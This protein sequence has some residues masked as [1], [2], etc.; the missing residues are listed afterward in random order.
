MTQPKPY[1]AI[2][3]TLTLDGL[4]QEQLEQHYKLYQGYVANTNTLNERIAELIQQGKTG[5]PEYNEMKRRFGFEYSGMRLHEFY[6][7]NL[8]QN[9]GELAR[10]SKLGRKIAEDF[11]SVEN[12]MA[13]F[14]AT[15]LM[16]GIGWVIL[17]QDPHTGRLQT[18]W[19]GDHENG[20]PAGFQPILVM[21]V[22][23]HA[24]T[25]DYKPTQKKD[26]IEAFCRNID[27]QACESRLK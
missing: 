4:S 14:K 18:F 8:K 26:Y 24:F 12:F 11:G 7:G 9:G 1:E 27:W 5:T 22:W 15:G 21:D 6:F 16:R 2:Q 23:E 25:V 10:D 3:Y 13:D 20:H 19:I 17:Y